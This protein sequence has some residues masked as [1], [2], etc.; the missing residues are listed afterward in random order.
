MK[1]ITYKPTTII[2]SDLN[3]TISNN[4][5]GGI[6][7]VLDTPIKPGEYIEY[8]RTSGNFQD[9]FGLGILSSTC[10]FSDSDTISYYCYNGYKYPGA[11]TYGASW[12]QMMLLECLYP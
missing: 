3:G 4:A 6:L 10:I 7:A 2:I 11:T 1:L 9:L 8:V 12:A 5:G